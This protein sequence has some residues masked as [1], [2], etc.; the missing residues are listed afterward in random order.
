MDKRQRH[1]NDSR[2]TV[3]KKHYTADRR[4]VRDPEVPLRRV[5]NRQPLPDGRT[6]HPGQRAKTLHTAAMHRLTNTNPS[7]QLTKGPKINKTELTNK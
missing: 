7:Q 4:L 1:E 5:G 6:I 3:T 2:H